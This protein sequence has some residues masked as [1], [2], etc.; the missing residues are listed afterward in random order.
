[1]MPL[2]DYCRFS[3]R[4]GASRRISYRTWARFTP[5]TSW[6]E[7]CTFWST[8]RQLEAEHPVKR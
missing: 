1:M 3:I 5:E 7:F 8:A 6:E 2:L 4:M